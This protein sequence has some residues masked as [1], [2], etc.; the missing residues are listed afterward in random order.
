MPSQ[1]QLNIFSKLRILIPWILFLLHRRKTD[2]LTLGQ[3]NVF[4]TRP[5]L[6]NYAAVPSQNE[7]VTGKSKF[8]NLSTSLVYLTDKKLLSHLG[9]RGSSLSAS[10]S[11]RSCRKF[12]SSW[13][14]YWEKLIEANLLC[15]AFKIFI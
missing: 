9:N 15:F 5:A 10:Q 6:W 1:D 11:L 13:L 3:N 7:R 2:N 14:S 8:G 12:L 4:I